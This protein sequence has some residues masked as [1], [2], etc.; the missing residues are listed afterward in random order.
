VRDDLLYLVR[1]PI[2]YVDGEVNAI[3]RDGADRRPVFALAFPDTYELGM[4]HQGLK[5]LYHVLNS[6]P[7]MTAE[8]VFA[9]EID[10]EELLRR[11]REPLSTLESGTPLRDCPLVGFTLQS[12]LHYTNVLNML[13]LGGI[14]VWASERGEADP[15]VVGGGPQA[16]NPEPL[17]DFLD[18][19][20]LGDGEE[21]VIE[22]VEAWRAGRESGESRGDL[23]RRM[24]G[25]PSVYVP[26]L[27]R[28]TYHHDGR[29][30]SVLPAGAGVPPVVTRRI[31][32]DLDRAPF[33]TAPPVPFMETT[34][35]RLTV[36]I[37]RGCVRGCRFCHAG[38]VYRPYRERT[39]GTVERL[40][41]E[42]LPRTGYDE[43]SLSALSTGDYRGLAP[44]V[45]NLA[46]A[47]RPSCAS[48]SLPSIRPGSL[49]DD[50]IREVGSVRKSG[51]TIAPE[52]GTDRLRRVI[53]KGITEEEILET[54]SHI[55]RNGWKSLKLYFMIGLPTETQEDIDGIISLARKIKVAAQ[56]AG[57]RHPSLTVSVSSFVPKAHTPFQWAP[58]A[59]HDSLRKTIDDLQRRCRQAGV[60]FKW[61]HP[62]MSLVEGILSRGDRRLGAV[63]HRVWRSGGKFEAWTD[64]FNLSRWTEALA[65][66]GLSADFY[67]T[68]PR[69][70]DETP[71]WGHISTSVDPAWLRS[72]YQ[73]GL[74]EASTSPCRVG[75]CRACGA[76]PDDVT[77]PASAPDAG[78]TADRQPATADGRFRVRLRYDKTGTTRFVSHLD[79]FRTLYRACRRAGIPLSFTGGFN[80]HPRISFAPPL[81]LGAE[82]RGELVDLELSAPFP[83]ER[84]LRDLNAT[85]PEG[86][87]VTAAQY[88]ARTAPALF[89][90]VDLTRLLMGLPVESLARRE[91]I[92]GRIRDLLARDSISIQRESGGKQRIKDVRPFIRSVSLVEENGLP[93]LDLW[94]RYTVDGS[95]RPAE[96]LALLFPD[97]QPWP[98]PTPMRRLG[99]F[100]LQAE[101]PVDAFFPPRPVPGKEAPGKAP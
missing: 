51:F 52:A 75:D 32:A 6:H 2:Q 100:R 18:Q 65:A 12:E 93:W 24:S 48:L 80:P 95:I 38:M 20:V 43:V 88:L 47:L 58:M 17:A 85:L 22:L 1:R 72:E 26:S 36:E 55:F 83:V 76:C 86:L 8:R 94:L 23:L 79:L 69:D 49:P 29:T 99:L 73:R 68:R 11:H 40:V 57:V 53:N 92:E 77:L 63:I 5:I 41:A 54:S 10:R 28:V 90:N 64:R 3:H 44:L 50:V 59:H 31:V 30:S 62:G 39:P 9:P 46:A 97:E 81:P 61:H 15:L 21:A 4:S 25:I 33:P 60:T 71:P 91:E 35:D 16:F 27:Y 19:V 14:P 37:A 42:S 96:V 70:E 56:A 67:T 78:G 66:E 84:L 13:Q 82:G 34:H 101:R 74:A 7:A 45:R 89:E 98:H 87:E